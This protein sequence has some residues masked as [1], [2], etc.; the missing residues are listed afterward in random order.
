MN[1]REPR[2]IPGKPVMPEGLSVRAQ[3]FWSRLV[4]MLQGMNVM[5]ACDAIAL[6]E[7]CMALD[8]RMLA[9]ES[10]QQLGIVL[11]ATGQVNPAVR[12]ANEAERHVRSYLSAFGLEP[13][14]RSKIQVNANPDQPD[15]LDQL[16]DAPKANSKPN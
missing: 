12:V 4:P 7:L 5:A 16:F 1:D 9:E 14:S 10:I 2:P 11:Q 15:A 13:S 6:G 8:H 3:A